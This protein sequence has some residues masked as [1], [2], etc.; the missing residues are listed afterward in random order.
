MADRCMERRVRAR[1]R[2]VYPP[3]P[4]RV[5]AEA[6]DM[7]RRLLAVDPAQRMT[8]DEVDRHPWVVSGEALK[9]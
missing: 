8:W 5:S 4:P 6:R 9:I 2:G 7:V 3:L 1:R